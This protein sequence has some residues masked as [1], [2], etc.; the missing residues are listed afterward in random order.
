MICS[1][2]IAIDRACG[3][4]GSKRSSIVIAAG[5]AGEREPAGMADQRIDILATGSA[6]GACR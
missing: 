4:E 2:R 1:K 5:E 3:S 6:A